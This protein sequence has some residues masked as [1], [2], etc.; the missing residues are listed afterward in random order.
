MSAT[1][2]EAQRQNRYLTLQKQLCVIGWISEGYV[3]DRGPGAGGPCYQWTRKVKGKTVSVALSKE[4]YEW[5][6]SAIENWKA[7]QAVLQ[8]MKRLSREELFET[9]PGPVR[10]KRLSKKV[11][12]IK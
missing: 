12:G 1:T 10:R 3:Q 7:A 5:L 8:E 2:P 11:L 9:V 6:K 4:Q